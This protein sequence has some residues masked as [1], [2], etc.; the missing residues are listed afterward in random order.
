MRLCSYRLNVRGRRR[1]LCVCN[2]CCLQLWSKRGGNRLGRFL[3]SD[4][5]QKMVSG[6]SWEIFLLVNIPEKLKAK[7][8]AFMAKWG[9]FVRDKDVGMAL[10]M[11]TKEIER[12]R[13]EI[14]RFQG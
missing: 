13:R 3:S 11:V 14:S 12:V 9:A 6:R 10:S 7:E 5:A 2:S 4:I 8:E 1:A